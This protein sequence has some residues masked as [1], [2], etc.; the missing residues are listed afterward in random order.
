V[1]DI[2]V[3][4]SDIEIVLSI[5][6]KKGDRSVFIFEMGQL[7]SVQAMPLNAQD[8]HIPAPAHP[9]HELKKPSTKP[10]DDAFLPIRLL[11]LR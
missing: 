5:R 10:D 1:A 7:L 8:Q 2:N 9:V 4:L 3:Y 11:H 6:F